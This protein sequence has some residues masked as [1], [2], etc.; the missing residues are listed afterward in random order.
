VVLGQIGRD[1]V[2]QV[3]DWPDAGGAANVRSRREL[4]G[5]KGANQAVGFAQAHVPVAV[6]GVVG[7]DP[8]G[9]WLLAQAAR[10]GID[11]GCVL[12]RGTSALLVDI[13]DGRGTRRLFEH[14]PDE[15]LLRPGDVA[16]HADL[17]ARLAAA[18]TVCLQAQQPGRALRAALRHV[19]GA[20]V[21]VDGALVGEAAEPILNRADVVRLDVAEAAQLADRDLRDL[22][23]VRGF[24]EQLLSRGPELVCIAVAQPEGDLVAWPGG[25]EF[26][27]HDGPVVDPTG[28]GDAFVVGLVVALRDG[29]SAPDAG[30]AG[31][32]AAGRAVSALGGR[33]ERATPHGAAG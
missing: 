17:A 27:G 13:T 5:G 4:L 14:V 18:D 30:R 2:L 16:T 32:A 10:D 26:L 31:V 9:E 1:L 28:A 22:D 12:R 11:T 19:T 21:V 24:A 15:A 20:R 6:C 33:P 23:E 3:E 25:Q 8:V 7:A 29:A